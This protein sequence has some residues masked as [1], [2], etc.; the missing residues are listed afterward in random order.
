M[1]VVFLTHNYPLRPGDPSGAALGTLARALMRRG[2]SVRVVTPGDETG[3]VVVDGVPVTRVRA[4]RSIRETISRADSIGAALRSPIGWLAL[5][6]LRRSLRAAARHEIAAGADLVHAHGWMPAGLAAPAGIPL[7]L[8][9]HG[10]DAPVLKASRV[11]RWL[12]RP[13]FQR[14]AVVTT[15]SRELGT[16][17]QAGAGRFVDNAHIH[18]MPADTRSH[19]WTRGGGGLVVISRLV[20]SKRVELAIEAAAVLASCGH[21]FPLTIVGDGPERASLEERAA[22]LGVSSLVR[23]AGA[24]SP[25]E[26]RAYLERADVM[27]F[28]ARG[29]GTA[30]PAIEALV[31]GV[32]VVAC[33][34]SGAAVD[35]VPES[36][37]GRLTLPA[38]EALADSVLDLQ[39]DP[40]RLIMGRLVG[41]SWRARLAPDNV[42]ELCEGWYRNAL[43]G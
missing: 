34:D 11:A 20:A 1:R 5:S 25:S 14:A 41:E 9:V 42:A 18:P 23:F 16:W 43:A 7:V 32:P 35:I 30:L 31:S 19:P 15:V 40:D 4:G 8:T 27:L 6:R 24:M 13:I 3:P 26:A 29:D 37:P 22:R 12:A 21:D 39:A 2:I 38:P 28:T 36:G 10:T 33:W 17:V